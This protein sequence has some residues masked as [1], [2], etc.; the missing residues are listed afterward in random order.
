MRGVLEKN[1]Q[2]T[3]LSQEHIQSTIGRGGSPHEAHSPLSTLT[4]YL[5]ASPLYTCEQC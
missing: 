1:E 4:A 5:T 3:P 2:A